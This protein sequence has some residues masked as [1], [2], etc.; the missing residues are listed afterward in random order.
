MPIEKKTELHALAEQKGWM[1]KEIAERW[2]VTARQLSRT[3]QA[4]KQRDLDA[5]IGLPKKK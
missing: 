2:G 4:P 5:V 3:A 1:L